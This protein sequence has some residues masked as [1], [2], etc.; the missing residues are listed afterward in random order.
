MHRKSF[1]GRKAGW[2]LLRWGPD[3]PPSLFSTNSGISVDEKRDTWL[4]YRR[5]NVGTLLLSRGWK[6]DKLQGVC[7]SVCS[8]GKIP[9]IFCSF[10][11]AQRSRLSWGK[12]LTLKESRLLVEV[13]FASFL[14]SKL[15]HTCPVP[16]I[17]EVLLRWTAAKWTE[18]LEIQE[19][20]CFSEDWFRHQ[21]R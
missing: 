9:L 2:H 1:W 20:L 5:H 21:E 16:F 13:S 11:F 15:A 3:V 19:S 10:A 4:S 8:L 6:A 14:V 12:W 17:L 7:C 18:L